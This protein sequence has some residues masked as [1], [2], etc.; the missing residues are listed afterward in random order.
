MMFP[1]AA[2][3]RLTLLLAPL[4]SVEGTLLPQ[5]HDEDSSCALSGHCSRAARAT[6]PERPAVSSRQHESDHGDLD[7]ANDSA[8]THFIPLYRCPSDDPSDEQFDLGEEGAP[9]SVL[10]RLAV[11]L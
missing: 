7:P 4:M 6:L 9:T 11:A 8:R 3:R 5:A 10:T 2:S 1:Y